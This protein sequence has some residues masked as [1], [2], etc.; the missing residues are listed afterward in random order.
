MWSI[1]YHIRNDPERLRWNLRVRGLDE[2]LI[3]EAIALDIKWREEQKKLDMLRH[4][5]KKLTKDISRLGGRDRELAI[6]K[7]R[8]LSKEIER[9]EVEVDEIKRKRDQILLSFPNILHESVPIGYNE[10]DNVPIRYWGKPKVQRKFLEQFLKMTKDFKVDYEIVD[11]EIKGHADISEQMN[12]VDTLRAAKV[13]G[14]RF[15]YLYSDLVWLDFAITIYALEYMVKQGFI[16]VYPPLMLNRKAYEGVTALADFE[17]MLYKID[18]EDLFLIATSE[19]PIAALFMNEVLEEKELPLKFVGFSPCFRKEAGAHG[20]D[21]KGIFRVHNFNKVEQFV[22]CLPEESW[23]WHEK[24]IRN[25]EEIFKGLG[26]PYR[27]VNICSGEMGHVAAKRYDLEVWM[28]AQ[29][30]YREAVSCSNVTDWQSYRL[31][32]RYAEKRGLPTKGYVHTLNSTAVATSRAITAILENYQE[33]DGT[34]KVPSVLKKYLK[35]IDG[36]PVDEVRPIKILS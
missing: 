5:R 23:D 36:A 9:L 12:L 20:R 22:F 29:G 6:S 8:E 3:D 4:E 13:A 1:L 25:A 26:L 18:G 27:I 16:P 10:D 30:K 28:P 33:P 11:Y 24:L 7:A 2:S 21:T 14:S 31:N 17:D 34:V 32:I 35:N 15:Y 19:H